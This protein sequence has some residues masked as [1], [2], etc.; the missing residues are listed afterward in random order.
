MFTRPLLPQAQ[1]AY[2]RLFQVLEGFQVFCRAR[3]MVFA[4]LLLPQRFQV[5]PPDWEAAV[6]HYRLR[7]SAFDLMLPNSKI[8][9]FC[10]E[11]GIPCHD[12][13]R[14]MAAH[15]QKTCK[16]MYFPR[17]DMHWNAAGNQAFFESA[18]QF[19]REVADNARIGGKM[20]Q[21]EIR[22]Q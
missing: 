2:R 1:E 21:R 8:L 18:C 3:G 5:Q 22:Y 10:R 15:Y 17:G 6:Q 4:V 20:S 14:A 12:P 9:D 13:T 11:R 16:S 19:F 7:R